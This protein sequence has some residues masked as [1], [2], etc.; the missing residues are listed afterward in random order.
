MKEIKSLVYLASLKIL[1]LLK[2]AYCWQQNNSFDTQAF[3][4]FPTTIHR[5]LCGNIWQ[6]ESQLSKGFSLIFLLFPLPYSCNIPIRFHLKLK[7]SFGE[8]KIRHDYNNLYVSVLIVKHTSLKKEVFSKLFFTHFWRLQNSE[9]LESTC[10]NTDLFILVC[11]EINWAL[12]RNFGENQTTYTI[13]TA[14]IQ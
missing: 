9:M 2:K 4:F 10:E 5:R 11:F 1:P 13:C 8:L 3:I 12:E 7:F 14:N 6:N